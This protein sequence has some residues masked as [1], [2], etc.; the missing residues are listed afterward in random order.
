MSQSSITGSQIINLIAKQSSLT[1]KQVKECF[2]TFR[3]FLDKMIE[4][5]NS[6]DTKISIPYLG[7]FVFKKKTGLKKGTEYKVPIVG[8]NEV[9]LRVVEE[10][11][12]DYYRLFFEVKPEIQHDLRE[13]SSN[14][15][16]RK[17]NSIYKNSKE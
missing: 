17:K 7:K 10:D 11:Q 1:E 3:F 15:F 16:L 4:S 12:P 9:E 2:E 13:I 8:S 14:R 6:V 5:N